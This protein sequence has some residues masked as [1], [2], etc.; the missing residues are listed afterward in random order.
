[1]QDEAAVWKVITRD[2][3]T[4]FL[5]RRGAGV[6]GGKRETVSERPAVIKQVERC[7]AFFRGADA[8]SDDN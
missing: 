5:K 4:F 6:A 8:T 3:K 7:V 2:G 1:M